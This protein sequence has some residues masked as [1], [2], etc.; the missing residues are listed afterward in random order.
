MISDLDLGLD[1]QI[2]I[3]DLGLPPLLGRLGRC[4]DVLLGLGVRLGPLAL[5]ADIVMAVLQ[6][7]LVLTQC[8]VKSTG[9]FL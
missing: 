1:L 8:T 4:H 5:P 2:L 3:S 6:S 7:G 9:P